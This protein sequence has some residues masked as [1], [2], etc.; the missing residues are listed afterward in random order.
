MK[1]YIFGYNGN[2]A[3][4]YRAILAHLGHDAAGDDLDGHHG[5][6]SPGTSDGIIIATPTATHAELI[7]SCLPYGK[8]ILCEK[9]ITKDLPELREL[10]A[11]VARSGV[12]LQMVSQ[13]DHLVQRAAAGNGSSYYDYF[14]T[15]PDGLPW[16]AL[17]IVW[18]ARERPALAAVSP[19]WKCQINGWTLNLSDMDGAYVKEIQGW[20]SAPR[21]DISRIIE[22]HEMVAAMEASWSDEC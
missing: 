20:L 4:R 16:D 3:S 19:V 21:N 2:M 18:H 17:Q 5:A 14:R 6:F 13:Y 15:G 11:D 9:P 7:R 12:K 8:P 1:V 10:M 22:S